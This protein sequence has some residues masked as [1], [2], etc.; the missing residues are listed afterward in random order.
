M[1]LKGSKSIAELK[2]AWS[3][4]LVQYNRIFTKL[5]QASK[6]GG[7]SPWYGRIK[8]ERKKSVCLAYLLHA[9]NIDEHGIVPIYEEANADM[10]IGAPTDDLSNVSITIIGGVITWS[11]GGD[12]KPLSV[13]RRPA[14][15]ELRSVID[16]GEEYAAPI[17]PNSK[18]RDNY[19]PVEAAEIGLNFARKVVSEAKER[20]APD[21]APRP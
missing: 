17:N 12:G 3:D 20:V 10:R 11:S 6:T 7:S 21:E 13:V 19:S 5:E 8:H 18:F 15:I 14:R 4:F 2:D 9:R 16:R 1:R